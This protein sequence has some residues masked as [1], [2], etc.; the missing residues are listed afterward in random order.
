MLFFRL[1]DID[2]VPQLIE[3]KKQLQDKDS[4]LTDVRLDALD[5]AR[6]VDV[7]KET[8]NRLKVN[9]STNFLLLTLSKTFFYII[10][11]VYI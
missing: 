7:L 5:K 2:S 3:L 6:E 11:N 8:I 4:T 9:F 10:L 1:D